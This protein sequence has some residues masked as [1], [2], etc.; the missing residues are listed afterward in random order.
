MAGGRVLRGRKEVK[1][2][3]INCEVVVSNKRLCLGQAVCLSLV[4]SYKLK[5]GC[6][7]RKDRF[8]GAE[9]R[10]CEINEQPE[11]GEGGRKRKVTHSHTLLC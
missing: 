11:G 8:P 9:P 6:I 1:N 5:V 7:R 4:W 10:S 2:A 3:S